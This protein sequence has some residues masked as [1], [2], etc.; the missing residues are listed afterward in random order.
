M[1]RIFVDDIVL[2][3]RRAFRR[4]G[5]EVGSIDKFPT[6]NVVIVGC[7]FPITTAGAKAHK[8][9]C[10]AQNVGMTRG[11]DRFSRTV[12]GDDR[13]EGGRLL[14]ERSVFGIVP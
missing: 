6:S 8:D 10:L 3:G 14:H 1:Y 9:G 2:V 7:R 5:A 11:Q 13:R 12:V 4:F